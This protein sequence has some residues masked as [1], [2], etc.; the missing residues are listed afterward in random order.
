[1][2]DLNAPEEPQN[3]EQDSDE[4]KTSEEN[5]SA[6]IP[7]CIRFFRHGEQ[8]HL[9]A[10]SVEPSDNFPV[11]ISTKR[12]LDWISAQGCGEWFLHEEV[13]SQFSRE[14][15]KLKEAKVYILAEQKDCKIELQ[16]SPDR[17]KAWIRIRPAFGGTSVNE[18][19]LRKTLEQHNIRF[20]INEAFVQQILQDGQCE[21]ELI[22][23][24]TP[25]APGKPVR[26]EQLVNESE[27]K[28]VPQEREDGRVDY[29]DLGLYIS[30]TPGTPLLRHIPPT[31]GVPG[32]GVD[33][34][35][36]P[37]PPAVDRAAHPS[38]G[39]AIS[40]DD[41][42][43]IVATRAGQ[44]YFFENSVRVDP[45]LEIDTVDPSTGNVIF[46]GNIIIRGAV[47][48]GYIVKAG[49]DLTVLD[50]VEG[51]ELSAGKNMVLLTGVYGRNKSK[52]VAGGNIEARFLSDCT[53]RCGGNIEVMDLIAH[54]SVEC[55]GHI[56]LGKTGGKGQGFG[57][58]LIAM[59]GIQARILGSV[60]EA[61]TL[62][63]LA[64]PREVLIRLAKVEE[65]IEAAQKSLD[66]ISKKLLQLKENPPEEQDSRIK[67]I[68]KKETALHQTLDALKNEQEVLQEKAVASR[69]GRI[70][71][72]EAHRGVTLRIGK[73]R[74]TISDLTHDLLFV[75]APE[76]K[77]IPS[78]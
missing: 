61:P 44:P 4:E 55:E 45:T 8:D 52:V 69:R 24:G 46:D 71:A 29:K 12:I 47:E 36:L 58:R 23:E 54:S 56:Y 64:P 35:P 33:G 75:E 77:T 78:S 74:E 49:Q 5:S 15:A 9:L 10:A 31:E 34:A 6:P 63:E 41:P 30:V 37:A 50:T 38:I 13:I 22:A 17:L 65:N 28:G 20:G 73:T 26:F 68:E 32:T 67:D 57:G 53:V 59:R 25:P 72:G 51:A 62:V 14:V 66:F 18:D 43:V 42:E 19:M 76:E 2:S 60:S 48:S 11:G 7:P 21:R 3:L 1:M 39:A 70:K 16:V 27:H 40:Q